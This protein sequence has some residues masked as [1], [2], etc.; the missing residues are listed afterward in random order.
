[1]LI[2]I[3]QDAEIFVTALVKAHE[4]ELDYESK[5]TLGQADNVKYKGSQIY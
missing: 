5:Q 4:E 2:V 1:M 3:M